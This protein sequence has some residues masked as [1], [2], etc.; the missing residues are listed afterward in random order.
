M[1]KTKYACLVR[2]PNWVGDVV[3]TIPALTAL[4]EANFDLHLFGKPWILHLFAATDWRL[5]IYPQKL[6]QAK[7]LLAQFSVK[8]LLLFPNSLSSALVAKLAGKMSVGY[9]TDGRQ[10]LLN[11][12]IAKPQALH[13]IIYFWNL[14]KATAEHFSDTVTWPE[15]LPDKIHLPIA[16]TYQKHADYLLKQVGVE[17]DYWVFCPAAVGTGTKGQSK[18]WPHW[19]ALCIEMQKQG[20][21]IVACP[22]PDEDMTVSRLLPNVILLSNLNLGEYA[23][24]LAKATAVVANDSGPMHLAAAVG[25]S[26]LG[27]FGVSDPQRVRPWGSEYLGKQGQWPKVDEVLSWV[28]RDRGS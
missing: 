21:V 10:W 17:N 28:S 19:R 22:G 14:A 16:N 4:Q 18:I 6:W 26:V 24:V 12:S 13:E 25:S 1:Q 8:P 15:Q 7:R 20:K 3:M 23:A 9:A 27:L 5:S 2:L 11:K